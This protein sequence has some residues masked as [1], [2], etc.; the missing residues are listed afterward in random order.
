MFLLGGFSQTFHVHG[1][2]WGRDEIIPQLSFCCNHFNFYSSNII[3]TGVWFWTP[4]WGADWGY[5]LPQING[6]ADQ[7]VRIEDTEK[8]GER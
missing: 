1:V 4:C 3:K 5:R 7:R 2:S 6:P 8:E